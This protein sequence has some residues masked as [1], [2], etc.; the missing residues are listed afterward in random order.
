MAGLR[1]TSAFKIRVN[2]QGF[3][4]G[5]DALTADVQKAVRPAAQKASQLLYE[6]VLRNV[7][8]MLGDAG[9]RPRGVIRNAIY[10]VYSKDQSSAMK[11]VYHV[12]WNARKAPH[13]HLVEQGHMQPYKVRFNARTGRFVTLVR[14][15][16]LA[17]Y[18]Q[19]YMGRTVP[20]ARRDEFF[21]RLPYPKQVAARPFVRSAQARFDDAA[22]EATDLMMSA[23]NQQRLFQ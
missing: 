17:E 8:S 18:R 21:I 22:K 14:P 3:E 13:A 9:Q 5:M 1:Q 15:E 4:A 19:K 2:L 16:K 20:K 23:V 10:Q 12:S 7:E 6:Q 11:A